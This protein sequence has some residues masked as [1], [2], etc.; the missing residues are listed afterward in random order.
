MVFET[1]NSCTPI[2]SEQLVPNGGSRRPSSECYPASPLAKAFFGDY[3][4]SRTDSQ[5]PGTA[6]RLYVQRKDFSATGHQRQRG[7]KDISYALPA[8]VNRSRYPV[9]RMGDRGCP[10]ENFGYFPS[11][12]SSAPQA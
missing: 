2:W 9:E 1:E 10:P 5:Y 12:E 7:E 8:P 4:D 6:R 3:Y 11:L